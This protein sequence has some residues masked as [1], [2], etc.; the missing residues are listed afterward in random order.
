MRESHLETQEELAYAINN[1][2]DYACPHCRL[3]TL[4]ANASRCPR[5]HGEIESDYW[6]AT[7]RREREERRIREE[8]ERCAQ[9]ERRQNEE[10]RRLIE[11]VAKQ[12][13]NAKS[14]AGFYFGYLLP[15]LSLGTTALI[16]TVLNPKDFSFGGLVMWIIICLVPALNWLFTVGVIFCGGGL[17]VV[18][19]TICWGAIGAFIYSNKKS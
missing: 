9:E 14:F 3:R 7:Y 17:P 2:G 11:Q 1:P 5:C 10:Q 4:L 19:I 8:A 6:E 18:L 15:I 16:G 12:Q 13:A